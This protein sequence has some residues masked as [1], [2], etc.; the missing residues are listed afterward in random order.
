MYGHR[1]GARSSPR[2]FDGALA[3]RLDP[4]L[5]RAMAVE[6]AEPPSSM[7]PP[8]EPPACVERHP[9]RRAT[10]S[11]EKGLLQVSVGDDPEQERPFDETRALLVLRQVTNPELGEQR[12][13]MGLHGID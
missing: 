3:S 13:Y 6:R 8:L 11:R 4:V 12:S 2:D 9:T 5:A 10:T 1:Y 7:H